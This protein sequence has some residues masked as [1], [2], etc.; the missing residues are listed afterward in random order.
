MLTWLRSLVAKPLPP[1][2][3]QEVIDAVIDSLVRRESKWRVY[4]KGHLRLPYRDVSVSESGSIWIG[5]TPCIDGGEAVA[6]LVK[7][8]CK[9]RTAI[10]RAAAVAAMS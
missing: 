5:D 9:R 4:S 10:D 2:S 3:E 8:I 1:P 6:S 7:A